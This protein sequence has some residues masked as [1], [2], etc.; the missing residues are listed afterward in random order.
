[1]SYYLDL[2][3]YSKTLEDLKVKPKPDNFKQIAAVREKKEFNLK[4]S[5]YHKPDVD[6]RF[7]QNI[8]VYNMLCM[9][10]LVVGDETGLGKCNILSTKILTTRG[11]FTL[12]E[13]LP[14]NKKEGEFYSLFDNGV[15]VASDGIQN[16]PKIYYDGVKPTIKFKTNIGIEG[17]STHNHR[18]KTMSKKGEIVWKKTKELEKGDCIA[19][20]KSSEVWGRKKLDSEEAWLLGFLVGDG[21]YNIYSYEDRNDEYQLIMTNTDK[22][23]AD[24]IRN[25][26]PKYFKNPKEKLEPPKKKGYKEQFVFWESGRENVKEFFDKYG[27]VRGQTAGYKTFPKILNGCTKRTFCYFLQGLY[28]A[29][30]YIAEDGTIELCL[31]S[32]ELLQEIQLLFFNMGIISSL[33][34]KYNKKYGKYYYILRIL[35]VKNRKKFF[36]WVNF[37]IKQ[38]KDRL[39]ET[40]YKERANNQTHDIIPHQH[41]RVKQ[42]YE[43]IP[44]GIRWAFKDASRAKNGKG[45]LSYQAALKLLSFEHEEFFKKSEEYQKLKEIVTYDYYYA[46]ITEIEDGG[47]E[48]VAD[49]SVPE[50]NT[51]LA[52]GLVSHNT[53][54][55]LSTY[56]HIKS[57]HRDMSLLIV[58]P[59]SALYQW[60][61]ELYKFFNGLDAE[62]VV[63]SR[64]RNGK[65]V[66]TGQKSRYYQYEEILKNDCSVII[67]YESLREDY[68][69][70][71]SKMGTFMV[72]FDE[73]SA[74]KNDKTKI[75]RA[76]KEVAAKSSRAYALTATVIMNRLEEA[77]TI[78]NAIVPGLFPG[79]TAFA[80]CFY[81]QILLDIYRGGRPMKVPK[82]VG[83]KNL[84]VFKD[85]IS[86]YYIGRKKHEV[87]KE[88]P[89]LVTKIVNIEV[90]KKQRDIYLEAESGVL[91]VQG[92]AKE[93]KE[94][95]AILTYCQQ[96]VNHPCLIG[97]EGI[98]S[99][100]E[101][102]LF[103]LLNEEFQG[104]KVVIYTRFK[105]FVKH[106]EQ[107]FKKKKIKTVKIT[108]DE[109][110]KQRD[111][112]LNEFWGDTDI[113]MLTN[114]GNKALNLQISDTFIFLDLPWS[115]GDFL[116]L[117]GR[118]QRIGSKFKKNFIT[119]MIGE[120]TVDEDVKDALESKKELFDYL[121]GESAKGIDFE[122]T[123][124]INDIFHN[125]LKRKQ[126]VA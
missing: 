19:V 22:L 121:L 24:K 10:R 75:F 35:E 51:Y 84:E 32:K 28:D 48:E 79:K 27:F 71:L 85:L 119:L 105:E 7:Y 125:T 45:N 82:I 57:K 23:V 94:K 5:E 30:G 72:I 21:H 74:F 108:G 103:R 58:C 126:N 110:A 63:S 13:L 122:E 95:V 54:E 68:D 87:S 17:Q 76:V 89:E 112:N 78:F 64:I 59:K 46:T 44:K 99:S 47:L 106:L 61:N 53:I 38:K 113:I 41:E 97:R 65:K 111:A 42:I 3:R 81:K 104:K 1:M 114:A 40:V 80:Q 93:L 20:G 101:E 33:S 60:K 116:Q 124:M 14:E 49:I 92:E 37:T 70:L 2:E 98:D 36:N 115:Y 6:L 25:I 9:P 69:F 11:I 52:N 107:K 83:Y 100:K 118:T 73:A 43:T 31:A 91:E 55:A 66:L 34:S 117:I 18:W 39:L 12:G 67:N 102:E 56:A 88:L 62:V 86:P 4:L 8:G 96:I 29:D 123:N 90:N 50:N 16:A 77:Y 15:K 120:N 109:S 26:L